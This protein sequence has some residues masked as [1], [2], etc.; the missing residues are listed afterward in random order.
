LST[1]VPADT[2]ATDLRVTLERRGHVLLMGL[3]RAD[4]LNGF[5][6]AMVA[7]LAH[8]FTTLEDDPELWCG[9]LFA[10]GKH[11]T[12][13]V[14]L[15]Q[16]AAK[17]AK[18]DDPM[19]V[20]ADALDPLGLHGRKRDKPVVVAVHG[21]CYTIGIELML[22]TDIRIAAE[23]T[24]FGQL[25]VQRGLYPV[26]GATIRF[27]YETGWG[28]AMRWILTGDEFG[29]AEALRIGLIQDTAADAAEAFEKA[30]A[31]AERIARC[32]PAGVQATRRSARIAYEDGFAAAVARLMPDLVTVYKTEDASEG[33]ASFLERRDAA[34]TGK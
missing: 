8:A 1:Q 14:Q 23:G 20:A 10:H 24:R 22:A 26:G 13:G 3:N 16:F 29:P 15:P 34:F 27:M 5:D 33:V 11:F 30:L 7:G 31:I 25:E 32:A 21:L 19:A 4:K 9:V 6:E 17:W 18:G 2:P 28:N 12:A